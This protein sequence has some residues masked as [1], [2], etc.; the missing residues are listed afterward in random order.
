MKNKNDKMTDTQIIDAV[1]DTSLAIAQGEDFVTDVIKKVANNKGFKAKF[2]KTLNNKKA[3]LTN[4]DLTTFG[5]QVHKMQKLIAKVKTQEAICDHLKLDHKE[6]RYTI[7]IVKEDDITKFKTHTEDQRGQYFEFIT[8]K[9]PAEA[10]K[11]KPLVE[12]IA[13]WEA[14]NEPDGLAHPDRKAYNNQL[15]EAKAYLTG[16]TVGMTVQK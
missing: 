9:E 16:K 2:L 12:V 11:P 1:L 5:K 13:N 8:D 14:D 15:L 3:T 4:D 7:R 10:P 6:T